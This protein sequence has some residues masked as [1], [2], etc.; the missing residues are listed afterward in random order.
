MKYIIDFENEPCIFDSKF[1]RM[2]HTENV[3]VSRETLE[4]FPRYEEPS[5]KDDRRMRD[6]ENLKEGDVV[7]AM[8]DNRVI[9]KGLVLF[10]YTGEENP[11]EIVTNFGVIMRRSA[12]NLFSLGYEKV[13]TQYTTEEFFSKS[14]P[15]DKIR[16]ETEEELSHL[17]PGD[18]IYKYVGNEKMLRRM[19]NYAY[20]CHGDYE[21]INETGWKF[22]CGPQTLIE[23]GWHKLKDDLTTK[24]F[25]W[26]L[27]GEEEEHTNDK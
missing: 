21:V 15:T 16:E 5:E 24:Q 11:Y 25:Y 22:R 20:G 18:I 7:I 17:R 2:K 9:R 12:K 13:S 8:S 23:E 14:K 26:K 1:Y 6:L 4:K 10:V 19:I 27:R 3:F